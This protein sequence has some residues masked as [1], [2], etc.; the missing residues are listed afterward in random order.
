MGC[1]NLGLYG[2]QKKVE[3]E[4]RNGD[5]RVDR[6]VH[7]DGSTNYWVLVD[8]DFDGRY[9]QRV[10]IGCFHREVKAVDKPVAKPD[11][12]KLSNE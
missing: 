3:Y 2:T 8:E 5:G 7:L 6:E 9:E 11:K 1:A 10:D 12:L 4:D